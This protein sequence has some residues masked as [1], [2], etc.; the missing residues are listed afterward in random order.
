M[1]RTTLLRIVRLRRVRFQQPG[2]FPAMTLSSAPDISPAP[3]SP[4]GRLPESVATGSAP[5]V[6]RLCDYTPSLWTITDTDL[7][8]ALDPE[9]TEVRATLRLSRNPAFPD[10]A[11]EAALVL[12]GHALHTVSVRRDGQLLTAGVD[13]FLT[14][15]HLTLPAPLPKTLT[16]ETVVRI[17]PVRNTALE[18]LY[19]SRQRFCTQCEPEGFR[20]ITWY[21]DRPDVL[22]RFTV[23]LMADRAQYPILLS[24]GNPVAAGVLDEGRHWRRWEDPFPKPCY[25][26]ALVA[27]ALAVVEDSFVTASGRNVALA[28]YSEPG[29]EPQCGHA[30]RALK[31][32][33]AWD[34]ATYGLEYDLDL[35]QIVAVSDFNMGA[36]ENKGLNIFNTRCVLAHPDTATD[37]DFMGV[38]SVIAHEYFH[39]WTGNR[40]TCRDWFQLSLKEGLTVFRDQQFSADQH[41]AAVQRID[42]VRALRA[43]QFLEDSGPMAHPVRPDSYIEIN[44]FYTA[45]VY[46]KGAEVVRMFHTLLGA[47]AFRAGMETY[48]RRHDG[49]AVTC[50][51][52]RAALA[53]ASGVDLSPF[54][55]WYTQAGT[56]E[57]EADWRWDAAS[58]SGVLTLRQSCPPTPGQPD[59]QPLPIPVVLGLVGPEGEDLPLQ[60]AGEAATAGGGAGERVLLLTQAEQRFVFTG[61]PRRPVPSLLRRFSAPVRLKTSLDAADL[62]H[63]LAHD[64]DP[65]NRWEAG[66]TL[67]T[68]ALLALAADAQAGRPLQAPE[69]LLAAYEGAFACATTDPAFAAVVL[70]LPGETTLA[71]YPRPVVVESLH[72]ARQAVRRAFAGRHR[73][74]LETVYEGLA[75]SETAGLD[76]RAM[77]QRRL[78]AVC[79]DYLAAEDDGSSHARTLRHYAGAATMSARIAALRVLVDSSAPERETVLADFLAHGRNFPLVVDKWFSLQALSAR[80]DTLAQVERLTGHPAFEPDNPNKNYALLRTFALENPLRFH[81]PS[82]A[83]Y[84]LLEK[85]ILRLNA[86]NPQVAARLARAFSRWR[87][88]DPPR[89]ALMRATLERIAAAPLSSDVY[90]VVYRSLE[91]E[92]A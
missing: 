13:Y 47:Q 54:A 43:G 84:R 26:F 76:S 7:V 58:A 91:P 63:L 74:W 11:A 64:S 14:P 67:A 71:Q 2:L 15:D 18:G 20:R 21:L 10:P 24:N 40:V 5:T 39:N 30:L 65:F 87:H 68:R 38:E 66:Q 3:D 31:A 32:A 52:F 27:G 83:G 33:M 37:A 44:N 78:R 50:E 70:S 16:L 82:G 46:S 92:T 85:Q 79:L 45:T 89:Q 36:M 22:S 73:E 88:Y 23:T 25:L 75:A 81:D 8:F 90:E 9:A 35:Y 86:R 42:D 49:H 72:A 53:A 69:S 62:A 29:N 12:D 28:L 34:E 77:G 4:P 17:A 48:I 55:L 41:S 57:L 6:I 56:P 51:D 61:L 60:Q 19:L 59:K 1:R 80:P